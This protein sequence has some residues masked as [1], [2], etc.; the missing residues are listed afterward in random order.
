MTLEKI[1]KIECKGH[2]VPLVYE[3]ARKIW[4]IPPYEMIQIALDKGDLSQVLEWGMGWI[5]PFQGPDVALEHHVRNG[6]KWTCVRITT[7]ASQREIV[8]SPSG[9]SVDFGP[10]GSI[11]AAGD[12]LAR[13]KRV[14]VGRGERPEDLGWSITLQMTSGVFSTPQ[15]LW[16]HPEWPER[17]GMARAWWLAQEYQAG[18][19]DDETLAEKLEQLEDDDDTEVSS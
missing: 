9:M 19:I 16:K 5:R 18:E 6:R 1:Q 2:F 15:T 4:A 7:D 12:L 17:I 8:I 14:I 11:F 10:G 3:Q 13:A